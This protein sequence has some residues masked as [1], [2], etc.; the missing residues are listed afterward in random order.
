MRKNYWKL[1]DANNPKLNDS[2]SYKIFSLYIYINSCCM[3]WVI[4]VFI[5]T[6][7]DNHNLWRCFRLLFSISLL[8]VSNHT[9]IHSNFII[10]SKIYDIRPTNANSRIIIIPQMCFIVLFCYSTN[11]ILWSIVSIPRSYHLFSCSL[12]LIFLTPLNKYI[13]FSVV[14]V[15]F[16]RNF[17]QCI[18]FR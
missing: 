3:S 2:N 11:L 12:S 6:L 14:P 5:H 17:S 16:K 4:S 18:L 13:Y 9:L 10:F 8:F 15:I 7:I 1:V